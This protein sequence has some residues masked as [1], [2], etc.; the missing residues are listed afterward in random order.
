MEFGDSY[1]RAVF[2]FMGIT[3]VESVIIE[4]MAQ[5]PDQAQSIKERA[6]ARAREAARCFA[7][8]TISTIPV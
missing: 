1:L 5:M 6:I 7:G 2:R 3:D 8:E 4:G